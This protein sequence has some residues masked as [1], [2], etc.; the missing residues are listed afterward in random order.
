MDEEGEQRDETECETE[1]APQMI[2]D[3][4]FNEFNGLKV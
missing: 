2:Y 3:N 4:E 1:P